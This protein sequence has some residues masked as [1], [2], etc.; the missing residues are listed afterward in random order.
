MVHLGIK[1]I[2]SLYYDGWYIL[3]G[4]G[5]LS[6]KLGRAELTTAAL[7]FIQSV[8]SIDHPAEGMRDAWVSLHND[9]SAEGM[10][11]TWVSLWTIHPAGEMWLRV[12]S[13]PQPSWEAAGLS[14]APLTL[15][16]LW[17]SLLFVGTLR[18]S[19]HTSCGFQKQFLSFIN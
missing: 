16:F 15:F 9:H 18:M 5:C 6:C 17:S 12:P 1:L 8:L 13:T 2:R 14:C 11:C 10:W 7:S 19:C 3:T 4:T